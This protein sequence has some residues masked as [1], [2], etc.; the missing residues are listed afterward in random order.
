MTTDVSSSPNASS[1]TS[2]SNESSVLNKEQENSTEVLQDAEEQEKPLSFLQR[3]WLKCSKGRPGIGSAI[4]YSLSTF[5]GVALLMLTIPPLWHFGYGEIQGLC[6]GCK[7]VPVY[8]LALQPWSTI[9]LASLYLNGLVAG[10]YGIYQGMLWAYTGSRQLRRQ[11]L[12]QRR[13]Q[14]SL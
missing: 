14:E 11:L 6:F 13:Q 4:G 2:P 8:R 7:T 12:R 9:G 10:L 3:L 5:L 1:E